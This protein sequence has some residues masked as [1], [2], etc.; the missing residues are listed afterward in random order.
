MQHVRSVELNSFPPDKFHVQVLAGR[1][2]G[3]ESCMAYFAQVPAGTSGPSLHSHHVDECFYVTAGQLT[4]QIGVE[5]KIAGPDTLVFIP[6][7][8]PHRQ[9]NA[10]GETVRFFGLQGPAP[11]SIADR[12]PARAAPV[13][14]VTGLIRPV[15]PEAYIQI[16][17]EAFDGPPFSFQT[18]IERSTGSN[19][20][21]LYKARVHA[22]SNIKTHIH[23][24]DQFYFVLKGRFRVAIGLKTYTADPNDL[25][26][27]PAGI[28]HKNWNADP[29]VEEHLALLVP[30]PAPGEPLDVGVTIDQTAGH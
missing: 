9:W 26:V 5:E 28:V 29:E 27:L 3:V 6:K 16:Q 4:V 24:F 11:A 8:A 17:P 18:L 19:C 20:M 1:D 7:G 21:R 13:D 23:A 2:S 12:Q 30:E 25:V 15:T 14:A 10:G 22:G